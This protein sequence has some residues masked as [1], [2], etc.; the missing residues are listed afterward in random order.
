M[1]PKVNA[2][3][4]IVELSNGRRS[5]IREVSLEDLP[6]A[7]VDLSLPGEGVILEG[8]HV[9]VAIL[10]Q[11][12]PL[13]S[14]V[15]L[16]YPSEHT[17]IFVLESAFTM[18]LAGSPKTLVLARLVVSVMVEKTLAVLHLSIARGSPILEL[19]FVSVL[20]HKLH[21]APSI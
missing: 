2:S 3:I 10:H 18:S 9:E 5:P 14:L 11:K 8:S 12:S 19:P 7:E 6:R 20:I 15:A 21:F 1:L 13:H 16:P 4:T 17:S